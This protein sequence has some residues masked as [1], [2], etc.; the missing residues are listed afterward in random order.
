MHIEPENRLFAGCPCT[1]SPEILQAGA[2][3]G[4]NA[5]LK[6]QKPSPFDNR[7][8]LR[9]SVDCL[10]EPLVPVHVAPEVGVRIHVLVVVVGA[11]HLNGLL[12]QLDRGWVLWVGADLHKVS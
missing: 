2:V 1:V 8:S 6:W 11:C 12:E 5:S 9:P 10:G 4:L 3:K 7:G